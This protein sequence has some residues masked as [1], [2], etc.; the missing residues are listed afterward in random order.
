VLPWFDRTGRFSPFKCAVLCCVVAPAIWIAVEAWQDWLG[1]RP[2]TEAIH[3]SGLWAIRLLAA[4]LAVTPLRLTSRWLKFNNARRILGVAA[5]AYALL[6]FLLYNL[7]QHFDLPHVAAEIVLRIYLTIG[8]LT[9]VG[10]GVLAATSTDAMIRRLGSQK[11][12][13]LHQLVY[14]LVTLATVHFFMQS[15]LDVSE[16]I[17]MAGIF[18]LLLMHRLVQRTIGDLGPLGLAIF[19]AM[20]AL[21]T[22]LGEALWYAFSTGAPLAM[23][24]SADLDFSYTI[25]PVWY[26]LGS[27]GLLVLAR[28]ARPLIGAKRARPPAQKTQAAVAG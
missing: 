18:A 6:H 2:V 11:W 10:L 19:V 26:V 4:G 24:L 16:P 1:P 3:Q 9:F 23:V 25:R 20:V 8:F 28:L 13:R 27:G 14:P 17:I 21:A 15:K 7:D 5:A 12:D 22:A